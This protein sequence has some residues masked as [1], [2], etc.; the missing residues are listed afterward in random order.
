MKAPRL[1]QVFVLAALLGLAAACASPPPRPTYPDLRFTDRVPIQLDIARV[2]LVTTYQP[3]FKPPNVEQQFPVQPAHAMENWARD[4]LKPVGRGGRAVF[5]I[6]DA[7]V[8]ETELQL[9][10]GLTGAVTTAPS[11]R[12]DLKLEASLQ[13]ID[14]SGATRTASVR[15]A[16]SQ[17]V[18][19][20]IS[21]NERD[22]AWY[23]MTKAAMDDFDRQMENEIRNNFGDFVVR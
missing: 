21:P 7:S 9:P 17:S 8:I 23:D 22:R 6:R 4:R 18:L 13:L 10:S 14:D 19:E 12:Y 3:P 11:E 2:E 5:T 1:R 15:V 20:G 16:R